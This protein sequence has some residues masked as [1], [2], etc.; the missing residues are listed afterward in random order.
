MES[1]QLPRNEQISI[2]EN[3]ASIAGT[4]SSTTNWTQIVLVSIAALA[5]LLI[6]CVFFYL[7]YMYLT[8]NKPEDTPQPQLK[9]HPPNNKSKGKLT[10]ELGEDFRNLQDPKGVA[11]QIIAY[12]KKTIHEGKKFEEQTSSSEEFLSQAEK[13][14]EALNEDS[15]DEESSSDEP[16][17]AEIE[18]SEHEYDPDMDGVEVEESSGIEYQE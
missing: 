7:V 10:I 14:L 5:G 8:K 2:V 12:A 17:V 1:H 4:T 11:A 9:E 3:A 13:D 6:V 16:K 15:S 18:N